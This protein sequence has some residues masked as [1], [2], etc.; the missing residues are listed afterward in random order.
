[1]QAVKNLLSK[2][3]ERSDTNIAEEIDGACCAS[4][5]WTE[6]LMGFAFLFG[7]GWLIQWL[8]FINIMN[9]TVFA[10]SYTIGNILTIASGFFLTGPCKQFKSMFAEKRLI[11]TCVYFLMMG[12]TMFVALKHLPWITILICVGIQFLAATWYFLSYIPYARNAV[13][14]CCKNACPV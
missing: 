10:M 6:R 9:G 11:A 1:M 13:T 2:D 4:L 7:S 5:S 8:A 12:L 3:Q 14:M